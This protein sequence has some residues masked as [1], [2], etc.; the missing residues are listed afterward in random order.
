MKFVLFNCHAEQFKHTLHNNVNTLL[1]IALAS[2]LVLS[3]NV[4]HAIELRL[5][6]AVKLAHANDPWLQQSGFIEQA[7]LSKSEAVAT[8]PSPSISLAL[9]NL[10][11]DGFATNQE[12]MT[13]L[14]TS[15]SQ[16]LPRGDSANIQRQ[17]LSIL[18]QQ[19]P[20]LRY[21]RQAQVAKMVSQL[22]L[23]AFRA[24]ASMALIRKNQALFEQLREIVNANYMSALRKTRQQ[25]ILRAELELMRIEDKLLSLKTSRNENIFG[26]IRWLSA[27]DSN[28]SLDID[29]VTLPATLPSSL[30]LSSALLLTLDQLAP[31][32]LAQQ[33]SRHPYLQSFDKRYAAGQTAVTLAEQK[34][35]PQWGFNA[36]YGYRRDDQIGNSRADFVSLGV[37]VDLPIFTQKNIDSEVS[38][39]VNEAYAIETEKR[40]VTR[41]F[42][43]ETNASI[44][45]IKQLKARR[46]VYEAQILLQ[47]EQQSQAALTAFTSDDGDFGEVV[48]ARIMQLNGELDA[49]NIN[50]D[51]FK[52][53]ANLRY[54]LA[55][56]S[57]D[58]AVT[59]RLNMQFSQDESTSK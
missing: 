18:A 34:Y 25:D 27:N 21:D 22:W 1:K 15:I 39:A 59:P 37:S 7:M 29:E 46:L 28:Y 42:M 12:P 14:K 26:L 35:Q 47:M 5:D 49:L 36:S 40:L 54:Y 3:I 53:F 23:E 24:D 11:T 45:K 16:M 19:Q 8:L 56:V 30:P 9:A 43:A 4:G 58:E 52:E 10:P 48:R 20:L 57:H 50:I 2:L 6:D 17:Q 32:Q 44:E 13:Q 31:D 55:V 41:Q 33:L 51:L 38:A